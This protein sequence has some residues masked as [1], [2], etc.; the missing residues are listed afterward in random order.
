M[1]HS[2]PLFYFRIFYQ[3][4]IGNIGPIKMADDWIRTADF[5]YWKRPLY[6]LRYNHCPSLVFFCGK[7][8]RPAGRPPEMES[9]PAKRF[10]QS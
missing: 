1:G 5:W 3:Q 6:K 8:D 7:H 10:K 2:R 9:F 4:L